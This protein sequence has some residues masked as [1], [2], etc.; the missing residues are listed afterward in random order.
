M[1]AIILERI[2]LTRNEHDPLLE[3]PQP[4]VLIAVV[5]NRVYLG[6]GQVNQAFVDVEVVNV[7]ACLVIYFYA[8]SVSSDVQLLVYENQGFDGQ[9]CL[10]VPVVYPFSLF[11]M[12]VMDV[13]SPCEC[14]DIDVAFVVFGQR[15]N[16]VVGYFRILDALHVV[17]CRVV[18]YHSVRFRTEPQEIV[19]VFKQRSEVS[20]VR[21]VDR[22]DISA[23]SEMI[24]RAVTGKFGLQYD[25]PVGNNMFL[26]LGTTYRLRTN[27]GGQTSAY[28]YAELSSVRDTISYSV[29]NNRKGLGIG[30]E[31]GVG[32]S[33]RSGERWSVEFDYLRSDW[34]SSGMDNSSLTGFVTEGFTSSVSQSFRAGFEIVPNRSDIRY[35]LKR[36]AYR[37]GVYYDQSYYMFNGNHVNAVGIT[38][39]VT[40]PV[41]KWYNGITIGVDLGQRGSM[42]NNMV[43]ERYATFNIGFNIHDLWFHKPRYE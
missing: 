18:L 39:G 42:R 40:L 30:D 29:W 3:Y 43:R 27:M 25:Q 31:L 19:V 36:C 38:L 7:V 33:L 4:D 37:A 21:F 23:G 16:V 34:R 8:F 1:G 28:E 32:I 2:L 10:A 12:N 13:Q 26:T 9:R 41:F 17:F 35:Y 5:K 20:E 14:S 15:R 6:I 24:V 22:R 11:G